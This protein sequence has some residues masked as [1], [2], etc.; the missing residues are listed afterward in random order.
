[1]YNKPRVIPVL[2]IQGNDLVKTIQF[3]NPRYIGDPVNSVKIFNDK[4]ADELCIL[5]IVASK[6]NKEPNFRLL[7]EIANEA[8]M[9]LSYGGGLNNIDQ[10]KRV[11][12]LGYEKV[13]INSA[14]FRNELFIRDAVDLLG[15]SG[16]VLSLDC[17]KDFFGKYQIYSQ[18]GTRLMSMTVEEAIKKAEDLNIGEVILSS[19]HNDGRRAGY[20][21]DLLKIISSK[22]NVPIIMNSGANTTDDFNLAIK[23]GA[24]AVAASS[25][26]IFYG[27]KN[28]VLISYSRI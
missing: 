19:I 24:H 25:M 1:M 27:S 13:V 11:I 28:A 8:F 26:F 5:D 3:K 2:T 9:P 10:I 20:D 12:N 14:F 22:I 17:K 15:S 18:G 6:E 7:E 4:G 21:L 23:A 16:V